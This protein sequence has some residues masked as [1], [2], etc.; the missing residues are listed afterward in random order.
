MFTR[1]LLRSSFPKSSQF[2]VSSFST[3]KKRFIEGQ[4]LNELHRKPVHMVNY[5]G[6]RVM[7][8][9]RV[10]SGNLLTTSTLESIRYRLDTIDYIESIQNVIISSMSPEL[11]SAGSVLGKIYD[12]EEAWDHVNLMHDV[13]GT[14]SSMHQTTIAIYSG[15]CIL[16]CTSFC[17]R[18]TGINVL[19]RN[20]HCI[21]T[22]LLM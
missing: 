2:N 4:N 3:K 17:V 12:E 14:F 22:F 10:D 13:L 8:L 18:M 19:M 11:F 15:E 1:R 6:S 20:P 5:S 21:V 9:S 7:E 16:L